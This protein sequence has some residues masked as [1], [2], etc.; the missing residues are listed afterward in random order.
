MIFNDFNMQHMCGE[1]EYF[2]K[3]QLVWSLT[4][5]FLKFLKNRLNWVVII[6]GQILHAFW[7]TV[8]WVPLTEFGEKWTDC[9]LH[10]TVLCEFL[11]ITYV[12]KS[13]IFS[14]V[15]NIQFWQCNDIVFSQELYNMNDNKV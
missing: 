5:R 11:T 9:E 14:V 2:T 6:V 4:N 7:I 10:Y 8:Y 3:T 1:V 15:L 12:V 13:I